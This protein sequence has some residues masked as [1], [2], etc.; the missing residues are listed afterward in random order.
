MRSV[1]ERRNVVRDRR[2]GPLVLLVSSVFLVGVW[3]MAFGFA[4]GCSS[5]GGDHCERVDASAYAAL[6][7][8]FLA[9]VGAVF[10][11]W[12]RHDRR[13]TYVAA[14]VAIA[15]LAFIAMKTWAA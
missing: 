11:P 6:G 8:A 1:V 14:M 15:L 12:P 5:N 9:G 3:S 7:A 4:T 2:I 13:V 10:S